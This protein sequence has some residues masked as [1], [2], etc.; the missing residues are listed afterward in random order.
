MLAAGSRRFLPPSSLP[1]C[2][3]V[4]KRAARLTL[5]HRQPGWQTPGGPGKLP[6]GCHTAA[7]CRLQLPAGR[8]PI[9]PE[10]CPPAQPAPPAPQRHAP[11]CEPPAL[12]GG[13]CCTCSIQKAAQYCGRASEQVRKADRR[14]GGGADPSKGG[15]N[16]NAANA[17][18]AVPGPPSFMSQ[19]PLFR[20]ASSPSQRKRGHRVQ[21]ATREARAQALHQPRRVHVEVCWPYAAETVMQLHANGRAAVERSGLKSYNRGASNVL[22]QPNTQRELNACRVGMEYQGL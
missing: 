11:G 5:M 18:A 9:A 14:G 19:G 21:P 12:Q 16:R 2:Q 10:S 20:C 13:C 22:Q 15:G 7:G 4:S 17:T 1:G 8:A 6:G 3:P